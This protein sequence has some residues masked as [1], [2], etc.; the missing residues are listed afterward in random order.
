MS[1]QR[2]PVRTTAAVERVIFR[3]AARQHGVVSRAQ[4]LDLGLNRG[5]IDRR[6]ALG[7]LERLHRG[8]YVVGPLVPPLARLMAAFLACGPAA[9]ISHRSAGGLRKLVAVR[10][11][12]PIDVTVIRT[13]ARPGLRVHRTSTLHED[14]VTVFER[15][16]V[17]TVARTL[18]DL[19]P[20]LRPRALQRAVARALDRGLT[21][22][23]E[24][25]RL[26]DRHGR[27][28]GVPALRELLGGDGPALTRSEAEERA[29]SLAAAAGMERPLTNQR[30][31][32]YEVDLLWP[33]ERVIVEVDG[34][35][36]HRSRAAF[37]RD[38][39]RDAVLEAAGYRVLRITWRDLVD[40][41]TAVAVRIARVL[42]LAS[43]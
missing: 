22:H 23:D 39:R 2:G 11:G 42:A 16:P 18:L 19:A 38:R 35:P 36:F 24:L 32:D 8:V 3:L 27:R 13:R 29:L 41:P 31:G 25:G 4:L 40:E 17:T 15:I 7:T 10:R 43:V 33:E 20:V 26:L 34:Y 12:A 14:E 37:H 30:V 9:R 5:T 6:V 21:D 28:P 1:P